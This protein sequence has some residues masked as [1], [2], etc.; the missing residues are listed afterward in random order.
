MVLAGI[1]QLYAG[2]AASALAALDD[3]VTSAIGFIV[4]SALG[5]AV[6]LLRVDADGIRRWRRGWP[7]TAS[8]RSPS[9]RSRSSCAPACGDAGFRHPAHGSRPRRPD[10]AGGARVALPLALQAAYLICLPLAAR[11]GVGAVTSFGYAYL[12]GSAVVAATA[13]S[14]GLVTSVPLTRIGLEAS[15]WLTTS[16]PRRGSP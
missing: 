11:E 15:R 12:A 4:A 13:A 6:I 9:P 3:Y 14:F 1:G 2:L 5:L 7:S 16:S 10:R 8:S